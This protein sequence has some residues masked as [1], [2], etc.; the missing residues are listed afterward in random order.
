MS[1]V[2]KTVNT[3]SLSA[4]ER[5]GVRAGVFYFSLTLHL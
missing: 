4:G 5:A 3:L 1:E 2:A